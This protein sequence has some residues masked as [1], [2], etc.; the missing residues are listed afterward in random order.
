MLFADVLEGASS[1]NA[2]FLF[3]MAIFLLQILNCIAFIYNPF[4]FASRG[5]ISGYCQNIITLKEALIF[6]I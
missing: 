5:S 2:I 1:Q 3:F 6:L 4:F